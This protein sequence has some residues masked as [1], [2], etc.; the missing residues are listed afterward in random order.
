[1]RKYEYS[2]E[3]SPQNIL[4]CTSL[5]HSASQTHKTA[6]HSTEHPAQFCRGCDSNGRTRRPAAVNTGLAAM[7][8]SSATR[9]LAA[10]GSQ[11]RQKGVGRLTTRPRR[12]AAHPTNAGALSVCTHA[13]GNPVRRMLK[14]R[15][16]SRAFRS[17]APKFYWPN[18]DDTKGAEF[19]A[20]QIAGKRGN[21]YFG[22]ARRMA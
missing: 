3:I 14:R 11:E 19:L 22:P 21:A 2:H 15:V 4:H 7:G 9:L 8:S 20:S 6:L 18:I 1:M 17:A 13:T 16:L 5:R 12:P 10:N